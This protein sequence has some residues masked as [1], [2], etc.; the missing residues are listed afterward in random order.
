MPERTL[1]LLGATA[2]L[3]AAV[4][5]APASAQAIDDNFWI[6]GS[7]F[8]SNVDTEVRSTLAVN[9]GGGTVIDLEDDLDF[10]DGELLP[11]IY[12]GARL[13][14]GFVVTAEYFALG[15]DSTA[16]ISRDITVDNVTYPVNGSVTAGFDT[17]VYRL[18]FG[19][20]F[21]GNETS[22]F[23]AALGLIATELDFSISG[24]GSVGGAPLSNQARR[25]DVLAPIPTIGVFG[26]FEPAPRVIIGGKADYF[27][28]GIDDYD[29]SILNL[30]AS[31]QYRIMENVGIGVAYRY[32]D[33]D[34]D[35]EKDT[36]V[37]SFD[38]NFWGPSFFIEIGF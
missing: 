21:A 4:L 25:K 12:A 2:V 38:Y 11:A 14:G 3:G 29:G 18:S 16:T 26:S 36:Y 13:G 34:L 8:L 32:V 20:V 17:K 27:G 10:D 31:A 1:K 6:Q 28:L 5:A 35:V 15:R 9:P 7:G 19:Y 30:Q 24:S 22:E 33:Y 37:A 23:G